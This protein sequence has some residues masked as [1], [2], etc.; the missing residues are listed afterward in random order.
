[1]FYI[2]KTRVLE[3]HVSPSQDFSAMVS[4]QIQQQNPTA[5]SCWPKVSSVYTQMELIDPVFF[6]LSFKQ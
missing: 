3:V 5:N 1:M 4:I 2:V 6:E